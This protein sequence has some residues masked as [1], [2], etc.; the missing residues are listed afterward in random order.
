MFT[1]IKLFEMGNLKPQKPLERKIIDNCNKIDFIIE[2]GIRA[3]NSQNRNF[4][5]AMLC[6]VYTESVATYEENLVII[7]LTP[8][9]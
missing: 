1:V 3:T 9:K 6:I 8:I 7:L 5:S 2:T 4:K